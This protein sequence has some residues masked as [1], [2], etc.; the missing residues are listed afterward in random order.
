MIS[1]VVVINISFDSDRIICGNGSS[2]KDSS[3]INSSSVNQRSCYNSS[4]MVTLVCDNDSD[5]R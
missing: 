4:N 3:N 2:K 5:K 1:E